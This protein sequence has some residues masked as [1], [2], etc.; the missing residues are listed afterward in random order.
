MR[1][2][3]FFRGLKIV[4]IVA[5]VLGI[6]S[7]ITMSLWNWLVPALFSGPLITYWQAIGLLVLSRLLLGG[8]HGRGG[9][10]RWKH[11]RGHMHARWKCMTPE[12][13]AQ[14]RERLHGHRHHGF[15]APD[16]PES[17]V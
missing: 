5:V 6:A 14:I 2:R 4:V 13:R 12:E 15:G 17:H 7:F 11:G 16:A 3:W 8:F 10:G 9:G 1:G